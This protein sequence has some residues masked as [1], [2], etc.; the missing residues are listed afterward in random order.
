LL[1]RLRHGGS[2]QCGDVA[3]LRVE[4]NADDGRRLH[5]V[6][7]FGPRVE[8]VALPRGELVFA[9][10][11]LAAGTAVALSPYAVAIVIEPAP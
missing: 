2:F 11:A 10:D 1:P 5:F 3:L 9:T 4:W 6:A 8:R 7:N